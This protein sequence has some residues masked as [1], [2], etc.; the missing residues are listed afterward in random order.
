M[1]FWATYIKNSNGPRTC[2][3]SDTLCDGW[4]TSSTCETC[5]VRQ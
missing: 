2:H 3:V 4:Q 1:S 5:W